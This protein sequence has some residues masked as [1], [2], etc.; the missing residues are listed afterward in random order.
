MQ[1]S[2]TNQVPHLQPPK[3]KSS[4]LHEIGFSPMANPPGHPRLNR[5][6]R[7]PT[8]KMVLDIKKR[9]LPPSFLSPELTPNSPSV[10]D[11]PES[12]MGAFAFCITDVDQPILAGLAFEFVPSI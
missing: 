11:D 5:A 7:N 4:K 6:D 9:L 3:A 1:V 2:A 12:V 10:D 8:Q